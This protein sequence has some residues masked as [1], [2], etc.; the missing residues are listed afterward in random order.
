M[1]DRSTTHKAGVITSIAFEPTPG[2]NAI[3]YVD[4]TGQLTRWQNAVPSSLP[5]PSK[6]GQRER[7]DSADVDTRP[8]ANGAH[9]DDD[10]DSEGFGND[11]IDDDVGLPG[12]YDAVA[13]KKATW[14]PSYCSLYV[15]FSLER[16]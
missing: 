16:R 9:D 1:G 14:T 13:P 3:A 10:N 6:S 4:H 2:S 15:S 8:K 11:W 7:S 5:G 12:V